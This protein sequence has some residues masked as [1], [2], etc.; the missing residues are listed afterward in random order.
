MSIIYLAIPSFKPWHCGLGVV[1][2]IG[3][4]KTEITFSLAEKKKKEKTKLR[5]LEMCCCVEHIIQIPLNVVQLSLI[6]I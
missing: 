6:H 5:I 4:L 1:V 3:L 2:P